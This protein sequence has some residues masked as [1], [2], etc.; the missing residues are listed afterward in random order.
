M[1]ANAA[2]DMSVP[3]LA[4]FRRPI[5]LSLLALLM[6]GVF[7]AWRWRAVFDP[8]EV[9]SAIAQYPAAPAGFLAV[10]IAASLLFVPRTLLATVAGMLF[11]VGWGIVWAELGSVAGATAGLL[12][13]RFVNAGLIDPAR[14]ARIGRIFTWVER[15]GWRAVA[16]LR[17]VPP[18]PHSVANYG[19]ALTRVPL[20]AYAFGSLVGQLPTTIAYVEFGAG[21][22]RLLIGGTDWLSPMLIGVGAL[23]LSLL[24]PA[25]ARWRAR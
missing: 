6:I 16:L 19:L 20:S 17:L 23:C 13:V 3:L 1:N 9:T 21:G 5:R 7:V 14:S 12:L 8:I 2:R 18:L 22:E 4:S 24:I 11:G 25:Y 10:H 15:G